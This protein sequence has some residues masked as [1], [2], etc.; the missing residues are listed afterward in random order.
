MK[1]KASP[2]KLKLLFNSYLTY[3][4]TGTSSTNSKQPSGH[5]LGNKNSAGSM[6][7]LNVT[8][9][10]VDPMIQLDGSLD[11]MKS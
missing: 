9:G 8:R 5:H 6:T 11:V 1:N 2:D 4:T 10:L 3:G 7:I